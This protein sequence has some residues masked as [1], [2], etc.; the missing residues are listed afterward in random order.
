MQTVNEFIIGKTYIDEEAAQELYGKREK[1]P[2]Q[3]SPFICQ[4]Q[5]GSNSEGF[6]TYHHMVLQFEDCVNVFKALYGDTYSFLFFFN[7]LSE[8]D[9]LRPN[10]LNSNGLNKFHGGGH[11]EMR[12]S[13]IQHLSYLGLHLHP[14]KM[15]VSQI[16]S[17]QYA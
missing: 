16:Q 13:K 3:C 11:N 17:M 14:E 10:G 6:W 5:Y 4:F 9:K 1:H 8:H 12:D 2:L 7:H 15:Q